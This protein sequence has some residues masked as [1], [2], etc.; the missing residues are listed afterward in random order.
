MNKIYIT[1]HVKSEILSICGL[2]AIKPYNLNG[3]TSLSTLGINSKNACS[4]LESKLQTIAMHYET[5]TKILPD[6][7]SSDFTVNQCVKLV[8]ANVD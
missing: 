8:M 3:F 1:N 5:G 2:P 4:M 7:I 6:T